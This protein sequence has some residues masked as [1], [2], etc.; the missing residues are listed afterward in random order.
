VF[1][2]TV[3]TFLNLPTTDILYLMADLLRK[4]PNARCEP[5]VL[6]LP[7]SLLLSLNGD[8]LRSDSLRDLSS[9]RSHGLHPFRLRRCCTLHRR[10]RHLRGRLRL[11]PLIAD[12]GA[13]F[14]SNALVL[15][16][17]HGFLTLEAATL[18]APGPASGINSLVGHIFQY[19][20]FTH[21]FPRD[22]SHSQCFVQR[23]HRSYR[24]PTASSLR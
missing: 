3:S 23:N 15:R 19:L 6:L 21:W 16:G 1:V 20:F 17:P 14:E 9:T 12:S 7:H 2:P 13:P 18:L 8:L 24:V 4:N 11:A 22:E 5:F 10:P